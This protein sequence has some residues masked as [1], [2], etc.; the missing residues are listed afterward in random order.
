VHDRWVARRDEILDVLDEPGWRLMRLLMA[1]TAQVMGAPAAGDTAYRVVLA[2][3]SA[4]PLAATSLRATARD[5]ASPRPVD[6][7]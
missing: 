7:V 3:R 6:L 1:G 5:E 2:R 4:T